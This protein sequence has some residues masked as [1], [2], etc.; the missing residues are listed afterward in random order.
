MTELEIAERF[1]LAAETER[2]LPRSGERPKG[3]GGYVLQFVHTY[4]DKTG[5]RREPGDKLM[6]GDDPLSDERTAFWDGRTTRPT[7]SEMSAWEEC[8]RW[9]AEAL[10]DARHR[11]ALWAWAFS[12][13]GGR[14]FSKWCRAEGIHRNTGMTRK[15]EACERIS[16]HLVRSVVQNSDNAPICTLQVTPQI[17]DVAGR[18][19]NAWRP[20]AYWIAQS[21]MSEEFDWSEARNK[22]RRDQYAKRKREAA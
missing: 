18:I 7:A 2:K 19:G 13:V 6:A 16:A 15:N 3:Y 21:S 12:K 22:T 10:D 14:S 4:A 17:R 5:W 11:R 8:L 1:I 20:E 9:T